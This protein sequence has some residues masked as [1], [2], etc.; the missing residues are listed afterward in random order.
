[1][2]IDS[3]IINFYDD[4]EGENYTATLSSMSG[5]DYPDILDSNDYAQKVLE[6]MRKALDLKDPNE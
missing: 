4:E 1:M 6:L 2:K 5:Q 3:I